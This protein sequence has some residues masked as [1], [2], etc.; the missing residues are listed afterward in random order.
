M[1]MTFETDRLRLRPTTPDDL[2]VAHRWY[3]DSKTMEYITGQPCTIDETEQR[4]RRTIADH[5][6]H[7]IGL[8]MTELKETGEPVGHC[9]LKP[10]LV[11]SVLHGE[12]AWMFAPSHWRQGFGTEIA[13]GLIEYAR[14]PLGLPGVIAI[15][16][17]GNAHSL[18]IIER[19]GMTRVS[20]TETH[21][22]YRL[23]L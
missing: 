9:G 13:G 1:T 12:L 3:G 8:C 20:A 16:H 5:T 21:M 23:A 10:F 2:D 17:P 22:T 18:T 15:A 11:D 14:K 7:G 4:L 19:L 6:Q